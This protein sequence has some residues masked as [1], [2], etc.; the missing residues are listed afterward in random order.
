M[1]V[2][3]RGNVRFARRVQ[4]IDATPAANL[5]FDDL[6]PRDFWAIR[7]TGAAP[8][9]DAVAYTWTGH[10]PSKSTV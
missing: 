8:C 10:F 9:L 5:S 6:A 1:E 2:T 4:W 3:L 7:S